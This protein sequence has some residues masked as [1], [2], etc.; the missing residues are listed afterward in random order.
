MRLSV[1]ILLIGLLLHHTVWSAEGLDLKPTQIDSM[2]DHY[3]SIIST[4]PD[5]AA[6]LTRQALQLSESI[7]YMSGIIRGHYSTGRAYFFNLGLDSA[8]SHFRE[9]IR[10]SLVS[11]DTT[12]LVLCKKWMGTFLRYQSDFQGSLKEYQEA[13]ALAEKIQ[14]TDQIP[15]L[16]Q[17]IASIFLDQNQYDQAIYYYQMSLNNMTDPYTKSVCNTNLALVY[18]RT[19]Q[20]D[21]A[22]QT[23]D[24]SIK[25]CELTNNPNCDISPLELIT[26]TYIESQSYERA[27]IYGLDV[28]ERRKKENSKASIVNSYNQIGL[29]YLNLEDFEHAL[30]YFEYCLSLN[31]Y[32]KPSMLPYIHANIALSY[33]GLG[34]YQSAV[35]H[36]WRFEHTRDSLSNE[37]NQRHTNELLAQ[38]DSEKKEQA[39]L[40]LQKEK[41][42]QESELNKQTLIRNIAI[43]GVIIAL[44]VL[45]FIRDIYVQ[46]IKVQHTLTQKQ[47]EINTQKTKELIR[48][49]ELKASKANIEGQELE[50]KRIAQEL[51]DGIAGNLA[52]IKLNLS[53]IPEAS[54]SASITQVLS[55]IDNTYDQVRTLSHHLMPPSVKDSSLPTLIDNYLNE[56]RMGVDFTIDFICQQREA[57]DQLSSHTKLELYRVTQELLSNI[58]KHAHPTHVDIQLNE[59]Q[60]EI[61]LM[62]EDDGNG[63]DPKKMSLGIGLKS[64]TSRVNQVNGQIH[65][66]SSPGHG[67]TVSIDVPLLQSVVTHDNG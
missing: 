54:V 65:I 47:K 1:F 40:L 23:L 12:H 36:L 2:Y 64:I 3:E 14:Y 57:I 30:T 11:K 45:L 24:Y 56:L 62:V 38:F 67:T 35:K 29:I 26:Q 51:H 61:N 53:G 32:I 5:S 41:E 22:L 50:R 27:L 55:Q 28:L 15:N 37:E 58:I 52:S 49:N 48:E 17:N 43:A 63:F 9:G 33:E 44:L 34:N 39:I 60:S 46:K 42:L 21:L 16:T 10:L 20:Y 7:A 31:D 6:L 59:N 18:I 8:A 13:L 19:Q 4:A 66:D 25:L